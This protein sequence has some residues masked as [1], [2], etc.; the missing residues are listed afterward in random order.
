MCV[1]CARVCIWFAAVCIGAVCALRAGVTCRVRR[2]AQPTRN[3]RKFQLDT[4]EGWSG[5]D[6]PKRGVRGEDGVGDSK[7]LWRECIASNWNTEKV[8][9]ASKADS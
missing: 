4:F 3:V 8:F 9:V 1:R 2:A 7:V 5:Y 6:E